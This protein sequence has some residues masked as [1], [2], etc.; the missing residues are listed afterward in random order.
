MKKRLPILLLLVAVGRGRRGGI[1][2]AHN[3]SDGNRILVSG[4][5]ELTQV[6]I[7]F[8]IAG[9]MIERKVRR[10]RLGQEGRSDRDA[11]SAHLPAA[12]GCATR[13]R[14]GSAQSNYQQLETGDRVSEGDA[15]KRHRRAPRRAEPGAGEAGSAAERKPPAGHPAG[16]SRRGRRQSAT[17]IRAARIG[18]ARRRCS[19]TRTFPT[20]QFDQARTQ[21]RQRGRRMLRQAQEKLSLV[22]EGPRKEDIA[23]ARADVARAKAAVQTAEANRLELKRKEAGTGR[24]S[25]DEIERSEAQVGISRSAA[26]RHRSRSRPSTAWCW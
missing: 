5:L 16:R 2:A 15:R 14:V 23:A 25:R 22:K 21:V 4:N 12:A 1:G 20:Q 19:R 18:T 17:R 7:S 13:P 11:R 10:R 9:R 26:R 6:D 24:A 3:A 8:K